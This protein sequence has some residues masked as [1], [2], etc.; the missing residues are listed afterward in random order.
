MLWQADTGRA[1][2]RWVVEGLNGAAAG[3]ADG[4]LLAAADNASIVLWDLATGQ[5]IGQRRL[6]GVVRLLFAPTGRRLACGTGRGQVELWD[7]EAN[8]KRPLGKNGRRIACLA[9]SA[10]GERLA[11]D[12]GAVRIWPVG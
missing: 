11:A 2:R 10:D 8:T 4:R 3:S 12:A 6:A 7:I 9:F 1:V 5:P